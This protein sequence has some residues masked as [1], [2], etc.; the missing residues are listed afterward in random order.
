LKAIRVSGWSSLIGEGGV[1]ME[2]YVIIILAEVDEENHLASELR[3]VH[4]QQLLDL[5][6]NDFSLRCVH[7]L[8]LHLPLPA[9]V[10]TSMLGGELLKGPKEDF[11]AALE[12][13]HHIFTQLLCSG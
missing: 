12:H 7:L 4:L 10:F 6:V 3:G 2:P 8:E 11:V 13:L 1:R 5:L 9:L